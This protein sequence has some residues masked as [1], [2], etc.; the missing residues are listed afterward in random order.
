M[1]SA[2]GPLAARLDLHTADR[3]R[4]VGDGAS[5][6]KSH[7]CDGEKMKRLDSLA[8]FVKISIWVLAG[9][10]LLFFAYIKSNKNLTDGALIFI[11]SIRALSLMLMFLCPICLLGLKIL[12][13]QKSISKSQLI[14]NIALFSISLLFSIFVVFFSRQFLDLSKFIVGL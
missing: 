9:I 5:I 13:N 12:L 2:R 11:L 7:S 6:A 4:L 3:F 14:R 1:A 10:T 8:F